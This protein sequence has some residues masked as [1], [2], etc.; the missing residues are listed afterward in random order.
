MIEAVAGLDFI[1]TKLR[2]DPTFM[3]SIPGGLHHAL[4]TK[5]PE[6]GFPEQVFC[7]YQHQAGT[8]DLGGGAYRIGTNNLY[9][10]KY[11]GPGSNL[12]GI[13]TAASLGDALLHRASGTTATGTIYYLVRQSSDVLP[14]L[15]N[16]HL[17]LSII[18]Q[19]RS[20]VQKTG[21]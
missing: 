17:T 16:G 18:H 1:D 14:E 15:V 7:V 10:V 21:S 12:V 6:A 13:E 11:V 20:Y 9:L 19:Y 8:D 2:N 5:L 4:N 3:A